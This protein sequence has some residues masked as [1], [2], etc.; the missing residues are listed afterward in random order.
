MDTKDDDPLVAAKGLEKISVRTG[1]HFEMACLI[2]SISPSF[3]SLS[4]FFVFVRLTEKQTHAGLQFAGQDYQVCFFCFGALD[5]SLL[6]DVDSSRWDPD[7]KVR[8]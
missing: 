7:F 2:F 3:H 5:V 8:N 6:N 4:F 1:G